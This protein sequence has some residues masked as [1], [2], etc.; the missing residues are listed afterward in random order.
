MALISSLRAKGPMPRHRLAAASRLSAAE[1]TRALKS[2]RQ[3]GVVAY[4]G[5]PDSPPEADTR[6]VLTGRP[7]PPPR[8][9]TPAPRDNKPHF[10]PLLDVWGIAR[11]AAQRRGHA[12]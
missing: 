4:E 9:V 10:E 12:S 8:R 11:P 1:L 3:M 6:L 7:L 2:A 5:E